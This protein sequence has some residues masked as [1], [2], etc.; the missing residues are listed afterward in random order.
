[1]AIET[2]IQEP[3]FEGHAQ[4]WGG[5][6]EMIGDYATLGSGP[7]TF[8][9][10]ALR[11]H[12]TTN[13]TPFVVSPAIVVGPLLLTNESRCVFLLLLFTLWSFLIAL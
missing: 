9:P 3:S 10:S 1:M 5:V 11:N 12:I 13:I 4:V 7:G 2:N 6:M 8:A